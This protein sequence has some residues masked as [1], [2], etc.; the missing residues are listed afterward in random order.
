[1][2]KKPVHFSYFE[3]VILG[4]LA[5]LVVIVLATLGM[6]VWKDSIQALPPPIFEPIPSITN[7]PQRPELPT[8]TNIPF[9]TFGP[10]W[11]PQ[12][13]QK[14]TP[15][16]RP[17]NVVRPTSTP[18]GGALFHSL[19]TRESSDNANYPFVDPLD[20]KK[21]PYFYKGTYLSVP[22]YAFEVQEQPN[23]TTS[24]KMHALSDENYEVFAV[25]IAN[26]RIPELHENSLIAITG[27]CL[28]YEY[29]FF[30]SGSNLP[31]LDLHYITVLN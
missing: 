4:A 24:F 2:K 17:T 3:W 6:L 31:L 29:E 11:T 13:I 7:I 15:T 5:L 10:T 19:P 30:D 27:T 14:T 16:P 12:L 26:G 18:K 1:M 21:R 28:G 8:A 22:G 9:P 25:V 20:L 23:G